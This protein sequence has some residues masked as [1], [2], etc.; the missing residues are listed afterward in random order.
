MC[1]WH[2]KEP[3]EATT[4]AAEAG[5][6]LRDMEARE[7]S[8]PWAHDLLAALAGQKWRTAGELAGTLLM[9]ERRLARLLDFLNGIELS[10]S[11][12]SGF[13]LAPLGYEVLDEW[14]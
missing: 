9:E 1:S 5:A 14:E 4:G 7:G 11:G 10:E 3:E 2:E 6:K 12:A 8:G 13:R